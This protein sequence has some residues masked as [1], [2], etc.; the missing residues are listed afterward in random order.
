ML[1]LKCDGVVFSF[2][3]HSHSGESI[4]VSLHISSTTNNI[5]N[6]LKILIKKAFELLQKKNKKII[7]K[8]VRQQA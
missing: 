6:M 5:T 1:E 7:L 3:A 8:P 2:F 4:S